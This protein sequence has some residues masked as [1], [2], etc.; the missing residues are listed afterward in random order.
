MVQCSLIRV[1]GSVWGCIVLILI[2]AAMATPFHATLL[3]WTAAQ[4]EINAGCNVVWAYSWRSG[5]CTATGCTNPVAACMYLDPTIGTGPFDWRSKCGVNGTSDC[6]ATAKIF[7]ATLAFL[8]LSMLTTLAVVALFCMRGL[9][10]LSGQRMLH[11]TLAGVSAVLLLISV[12]IFAAELHTATE[13]DLNGAPCIAGPCLGF[14]GTRTETFQGQIV[15]NATWGPLGWIVA[16]TTFFLYLYTMCCA[17]SA[18]IDQFQD[19]DTAYTRMH[20]EVPPL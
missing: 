3:E 15:A 11:G 20:G 18:G 6:T 14:A 13:T 12:I 2:I 9:G 5:H 7:D 19:G 8:V 17:F 1:C 10:K 16:L 4:G